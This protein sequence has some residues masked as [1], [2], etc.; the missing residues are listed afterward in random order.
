MWCS[1]VAELARAVKSAGGN[2]PEWL[3]ETNSTLR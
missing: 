2:P 1:D 3:L